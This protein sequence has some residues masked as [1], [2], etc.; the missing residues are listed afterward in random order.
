[1]SKLLITTKEEEEI[2]YY[3]PHHT[4]RKE[5]SIMTKVRVVFDGSAKTLSDLSIN[6]IQYIGL[7]VLESPRE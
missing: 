6:D 1:M 2:A 3:L 5:S 4:V 7:V